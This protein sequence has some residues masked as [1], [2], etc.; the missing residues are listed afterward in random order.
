[1]EEL[2][3]MFTRPINLSS[4]T[5][6]S[7]HIARTHGMGQRGAETLRKWTRKYIT[8]RIYRLDGKKGER[9]HATEAYLFGNADLA[10]EITEHLQT[11]RK[12]I[13]AQDIIDIIDD[14][15]NQIKF[16]IKSTILLQTA[17]RWLHHMHF[18]WTKVPSCQYIDSH[19][20]QDV[21]Q[22][23]QQVLFRKCSRSL[24]V[25]R[26][27]AMGKSTLTLALRGQKTKK[28]WSAIMMNWL[29]MQMQKIDSMG[30]RL[31]GCQQQYVD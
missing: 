28:S 31:G 25:W 29:F 30:A 27:I 14:P 5:H 8:E 12:Y 2:L 11:I 17:Q 21:I 20:R 15:T 3:A 13:K 23:R 24:I 1:M 7:I 16:R 26:N 18:W 10:C 22:Y 6:A 19:E 4:W 9:S